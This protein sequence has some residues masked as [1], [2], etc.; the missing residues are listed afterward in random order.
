VT[1]ADVPALVEVL[2]RAFDDDPW[3]DWL[4][5]KDARRGE[6]I[7]HLFRVC[8]ADLALRHDEC[9]TTEDR[10]GASLWIPPGRWKVGLWD[11][12]R[13]LPDA[14]RVSGLRRLPSIG[15]STAAIARAHPPEP[16]W[17]LLQ[18]GVDPPAQGRGL[19]RALLRP[20]LERC[21]RER[22]GA[23]LETARESNLGFYA[24]DGF[25]IRSVHEI[26]GG[27][28]VWGLWRPPCA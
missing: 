22:A 25:A 23:Y 3:V 17:Y 6:A 8:L 10:A 12:L 28:T 27:P 7:R 21:D 16:H 5:R 15:R 1:G 11:Q 26:P 13:L 18:L 19:G 2:A 14:A 4:A 20:V 9:W 24:R